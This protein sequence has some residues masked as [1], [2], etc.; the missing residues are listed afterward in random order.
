MAI[1]P[2]WARAK[3]LREKRSRR[4]P[5][6][7]RILQ[8]TS[9][10]ILTKGVR[11]TPGPVVEQS[12]WHGYPSSYVVFLSCFDKV[13][14]DQLP[15]LVAMARKRSELHKATGDREYA[16]CLPFYTGSSVHIFCMLSARTAYYVLV[17]FAEMTAKKSAVLTSDFARMIFTDYRDRPIREF[18]PLLRWVETVTIPSAD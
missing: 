4:S 2:R 8:D 18:V 3:V 1:T 11:V 13:P 14:D 15:P 5:K 17:N 9:A 6:S 10:C 16:T 7:M 12:R